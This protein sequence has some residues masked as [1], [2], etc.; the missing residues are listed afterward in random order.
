MSVHVGMHYNM[1]VIPRKGK[2]F[3]EHVLRD[4]LAHK[5]GIMRCKSELIVARACHKWH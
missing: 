4:Y 3:K 1:L 5:I 2:I